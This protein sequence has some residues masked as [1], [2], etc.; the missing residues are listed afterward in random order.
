MAV[1]KKK[2]SPMRQGMRNMHYKVRSVSVGACANCGEAKLG[3]H[4]CKH[5]GFY[6]GK[7][8]IVSKKELRKLKEQ[9]KEES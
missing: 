8:V 9:A 6:K 1:P 4:I 3:H 7:K 5:C 2:S